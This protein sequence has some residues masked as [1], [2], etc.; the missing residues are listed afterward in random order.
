MEGGGGRDVSGMRLRGRGR[1]RGRAVRVH[2]VRRWHADGERAER[3][4]R[5]FLTGARLLA[6]GAVLLGHLAVLLLWRDPGA[7]GQRWALAVGGVALGLGA[8]WVTVLARATRWVRSGVVADAGSGPPAAT[9]L[10]PDALGG[11]AD[12]L[13]DWA[14]LLHLVSLCFPLGAL[15]AALASSADEQGLRE[16][17]RWG[18][19]GFALLLTAI[20]GG[21]IGGLAFGLV[22]SDEECWTVR[23][24]L[25]RL[26][27]YAVPFLLAAPWLAGLHTGWSAL[28]VG[29]ALLWLLIAPV[30][31]VGSHIPGSSSD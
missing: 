27:R 15:V 2:E 19:T 25:R 9:G 23:G 14:R 28:S 7:C 17:S 22:D 21:V 5:R 3:T 18:A 24:A 11:P 6:G 12:R 20:L 30:N 4:A 13:W 10:L 1:V 29:A 8:L 31:H 16:L 26:R